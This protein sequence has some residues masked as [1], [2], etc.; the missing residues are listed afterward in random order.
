MYLALKVV[1]VL[2]V[3]VFLGNITTGIFWKVIADR[4][5]DPKIM[6]HTLD[7]IIG[8]DRWFTIPGI[9]VILLAGFATAGVGHV[10]ILSTGWILWS[11]ALFV[12]AG[13]AFGP[14]SR[15]QRQ[16]AAI[17]HQGSDSGKFDWTLYERRSEGWNFW[18]AIA[19]VAPLIAVVLMVLKP[20][21][22]AFHL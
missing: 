22:P 3:I 11:L 6:A 15:F 18:G 5:R 4:T 8:A 1:H 12:I 20:T 10:P 16:M 2:A 17:A 19:L 14:V 21:L 7:G 9:I 13:I